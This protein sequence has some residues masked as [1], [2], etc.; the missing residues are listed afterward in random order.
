MGRSIVRL[1]IALAAILATGIF[2][3]NPS[4]RP[5][6]GQR[7]TVT[8]KTGNYTITEG[9]TGAIFTTE[10]AAGE[11]VFTLPAVAAGLE[12]TVYSAE[13]QNLVLAAPTA[14]TM[15]AFNDVA[16]T[17]VSLVTAN[18]LAGGGFRVWSD[19]AKWMVAP[20]VDPAATV[21]VA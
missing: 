1:V 8:A 3:T 19:G 11:V 7:R 10:G 14:D 16:A 15:I 6:L 2:H 21:T 4:A 12:Y 13:S 17:Q 9:E 20:I 18:M 5:V